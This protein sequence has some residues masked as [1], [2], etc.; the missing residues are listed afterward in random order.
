MAPGVA[1]FAGGARPF[2]AG[3]WRRLRGIKHPRSV[4][5]AAVWSG[6]AAGAVA[7]LLVG[8]FFFVTW[9]MPSTDDLWEARNGQSITFL[10]RNGHVILREGAQNAPP[11]ELASL[12]AY[13]A[14]AFIAVEDRRFYQHFGV[15]VE[16][17][18]RIGIALR[19]RRIGA[20]RHELARCCEKGG[21]RH[22]SP[23]EGTSA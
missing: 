8:F 21:R 4:R 13:V 17:A 5:E 14:Q 2:F 6:W 15:D 22:R 19:R 11:V 20:A 7:L 9:G 23:D 16:P 18:Q 12:P 10:D 1:A 3:A